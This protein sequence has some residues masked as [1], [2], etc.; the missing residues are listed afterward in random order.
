MLWDDDAI[1]SGLKKPVIRSNADEPRRLDRPTSPFIKDFV[2]S[3]SYQ[4]CH[5]GLLWFG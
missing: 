1:V 4:K 3:I 5:A 2:A